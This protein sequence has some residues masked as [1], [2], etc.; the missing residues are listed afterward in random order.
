M[1]RLRT[2]VPGHFSSHSALSSYGLFAPLTLWRLSV[3]LRPLVQTLR[4]FPASGAPWS[5]AMPRSLGRGR[6]NNNNSNNLLISLINLCT[7]L[8][9]VVGSSSN[10][11]NCSSP[12]KSASVFAGCL[13]FHF[14]VF[15][16][17]ALHSRGRGC[18]FDLRRATYLEDLICLS[19]PAFPQLNFLQRPLSREIHPPSKY[20]RTPLLQSIKIISR[21][22]IPIP[23][24]EII[25]K[26]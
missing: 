4:S 21:L 11:S 26:S 19:A 20:L 6:V 3:F 5:S 23:I 18:L 9:S 22:R 2:L 13:R 10:F 15:L 12:R 7:L 14:S 17:K 1:Q 8:R 16:R 24:I 25:M